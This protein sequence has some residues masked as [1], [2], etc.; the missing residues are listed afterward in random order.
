[1]IRA[2][3]KAEIQEL[4]DKHWNPYVRRHSALTEKWKI[5]KESILRQHAGWSANSNMH[6]KCVYYFGNESSES[7]L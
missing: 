5:L 6:Q 3:D 1:M 2:K 4:L 7:I